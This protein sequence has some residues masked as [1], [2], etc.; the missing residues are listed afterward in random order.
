[1]RRHLLLLALPCLAAA[2][3]AP[4]L[5]APSSAAGVRMTTV[6]TVGNEPL[7]AVAPD[8]PVYVAALQYLYRSTDKGAHWKALPLP[9]NSGVTEYKSDSSIAVDPGGRLY[10][11]FDY[12]YAGITAV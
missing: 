12:P 4:A 11:T 8:G 2:M 3:V 9:V 5:A 1:M 6:G 10:Y 7:T